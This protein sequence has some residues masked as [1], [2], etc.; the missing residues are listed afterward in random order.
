MLNWTEY[1]EDNRL[2]WNARTKVHITSA[3][4]DVAGFLGG[5]ESLKSPELALIGDIRDKKVLHLQCHFGQ[6]TLSLARHG[7]VATGLDISDESIRYARDLSQQMGIGATFICADVYTMTEHFDAAAFDMV[8]VSYGAIC[9]LPD[10]SEWARQISTILKPDGQL[11]LVEFH[12]I[13]YMFDFPTKRLAYPYFSHA[14]P[15]TEDTSGTY[16]APNAD[17]QLKDHFWTHPISEVLE[18]ILKY[19]MKLISFK[20]W[21][22]SPY[23]C[24]ENMEEVALETYRFSPYE[25]PIPHVYGLIAEK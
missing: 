1:S 12:P 22:Y 11:I 10:L 16:A 5:K 2:S 6:D 8:Y 17:I 3:F 18:S 13:L 24:F 9:W 4:Y 15:I 19:N 21:D 14:L 23:N 7:A 25:H 20:E